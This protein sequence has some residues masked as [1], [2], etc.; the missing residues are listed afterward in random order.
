MGC[1]CSKGASTKR[2]GS[3]RT[4]EKE[5]KKSSSKRLIV[6]TKEDVLVEVDEN[7]GNDA[8]TRLISTEPIEKSAGSTPPA[9][10]EGEKKPIVLEKPEVPKVQ[11][12]AATSTTEVGGQPQINR[13]FN[14]RNGVDGAQVVAGWPSWLTTVAGEA[15]KGWVP[16]KAD[17]FE[18]LDKIGQG[19]YSSVYRARD[20]ET[21]KIV[22]LKKVRF[23]NMDP[24]SVRFM[25]REILILR[26]LDHPNVMKLEG[27]VTSRVSGN[28]YLVF[29][30]MEHDLAGLAASPAVKFTESQIKCYI[31]QLLRG[32]EHCHSRGVLHRDIKGSNLL[33]DNNGNL[34]IGDFG[35]ATLNQNN[36]RQPLTSR[37]VTLW[38]R[39]PE[40]L[41]GATDYGVAVDLWS[42]GC[43][44]AELFAGKPIMPGRTE[45]EQLHK[46]FKL[47]GSPSEE[48]WKKSKLPHA[49][50]F[51]P[52]Q[53]Y[54][55]CLAN[56]FN[57]F[58]PSAL[59][60]LDSLLAFEPEYRGSAT[61]A[62]QSEFFTTKPLPCDPSSLPKYPPSKEFDAKMRDEEARR[63]RG[64]GTKGSGVE[65]NRKPAKQSKAV[66]APD[67]NA[68]LPASI[69]KW[70]QQSNQTS[71]SEKYNREEDGG[72]G[73]PFDPSRGSL[74][75]GHLSQV[76]DSGNSNGHGPLMSSQRAFDSSRFGGLSA[77]KSFRP[78]GAA[79]HLSRFSNSV[80]AHGSSRF[81]MS[82]EIS[83]HSQWP[84]EHMNGKY[85]QLNDSDSSYS[86]LGKDSS[87]KKD[88][89]AA[90]KE[91]GAKNRIHYSGPLMPP[92]GNIDEMLKEH[93]KQIQ[94]AVR[95]A[96]LD[97]NK[98]KEHNDNGQ[99][100][101]LL[102]YTSNGRLMW[103]TLNYGGRTIFLEE[104]EAWIQQIKKRFPM[105]ESYHVTYDS[106]VNQANVL[107]EAGK[108]PECTTIAD[109]RYSMCQL[110]LKGLPSEIY[111]TKWDLIMV[112]AP[113]G[114][115]EDAPGRMTAIYTAG[116]M[117]RNREEGETHVC[118]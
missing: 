29:E 10:D 63:Q 97:K 43:I 55:R 106:K 101:S 61:L 4:K 24:E 72:S 71:V 28:L 56:T 30:Y 7:G 82:R 83:T 111:D 50:I 76:S 1:V 46:I 19:T 78:H 115:Y 77:H 112:D 38:Y 17:S 5:K 105:L 12:P 68:E 65:S 116:M 89:H 14:V 99:T 6:S 110:A 11:R 95:K 90:G 94:Q 33:I 44:V 39:P 58:P 70:K 41:L 13:I 60:L 21:G 88:K 9:W 109:P 67:A 64:G 37:V 35:L 87:N 42:S 114:Y 40:L 16:R 102:H 86:L 47:C 91:P 92:G 75:N 53:P 15:I 74:Y 103:H 69:Q 79:A 31:E 73:F 107:I 45:V 81:D 49:T 100:E 54:K 62:L 22:A 66:P 32:L 93:E 96:R 25:A 8:T 57:D 52:Q 85:N 80:A 20:V 18:K 104:D 23:I 51:K 2:R 48:Y 118:A 59:V 34:K 113:T 117:A 36:Q 26:R 3:N 108:G 84:E 27:L 98:K